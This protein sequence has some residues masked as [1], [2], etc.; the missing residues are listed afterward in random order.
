MSVTAKERPR[1][2]IIG[3]GFGGLYAAQSLRGADLDV[4]LV[5]RTNHHLFQP[6]L[7]QVATAALSPSEIAVPIRSIL[8][9]QRNVTVRLQ[10]AVELDLEGRTVR[11]TSGA[12]LSYDRLIVATGTVNAYFGKDEWKEKAPGLK[13]LNDAM[14]IRDRLFL[15]FEKAEIS[16]DPG[17]IESLMSFVVIGGGPT[18]VELAGAIGEISRIALLN[19]FRNIDP[20]KCKIYLIQGEERILPDF[21]EKLANKA[22]RELERMGVTVMTDRMV[23]D[24]TGEGVSAG[25]QF[26]R[27]ANIIWAAGNRGAPLLES[28]GVPL[29]DMGRVMV[30][31]DLSLKEHPEVFVIGDAAVIDGSD[32]VPLPGIAPVAIQEAKHVAGIL[33]R[34]EPVGQRAAFRYFDKGML[35]TIGNNRSVASV[36]GFEFGGLAAWIFWAVVHLMYLMLFSNRIIVFMRWVFAYMTGYRGGRIIMSIRNGMRK[37][38]RES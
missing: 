34:A 25:G 38:D 13:T 4:V 28:L 33:R 23:T 6:L 27:A 10:E 26:I 29:D 20:G 36:G 35:A 18:G 37:K 32:G 31:D 22:L 7:Y 3:G 24:I 17:E 2:V 11:M 12:E 19:N 14:E 21:S 5:D 1:V 9:K 16:E 8:R 30:E 15:A